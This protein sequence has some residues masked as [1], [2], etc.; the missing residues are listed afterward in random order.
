MN[1]RNIY[2][3]VQQAQQMQN[4]N[5]FPVNDLPQMNQMFNN[6][7]MN[8]MNSPMDQILFMSNFFQN[9]NM[10]QMMGGNPNFNNNNMNINNSM[11]S[12]QRINI[13]FITL[14]GARINMAFNSDETVDGALT[15]FLKR[16]NLDYL[17]NNLG[18]KLNF[19]LSAEKLSF[20]DYRKLKDLILMP[21]SFTNIFVHDTQ[22]LIGA[23]KILN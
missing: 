12:A 13:V 10:P 23:K 18:G 6:M 9:Q 4:M 21:S 2:Q 16:V 17:I 1:W 14:K 22:N 5:F 15:K 3:T 20:G 19:V 11:K 7:N 8:Q